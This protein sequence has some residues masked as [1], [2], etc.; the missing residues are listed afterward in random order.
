M[1][2]TSAIAELPTPAAEAL[3]PK[4]KAGNS[5][6]PTC[7]GH[8]LATHF[9]RRANGHLIVFAKLVRESVGQFALAWR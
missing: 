3:R 7:N 4:P 2:Q 1:A 5:L 8:S 6:A 9:T